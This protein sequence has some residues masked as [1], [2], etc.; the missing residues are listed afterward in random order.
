[1]P[2]PTISTAGRGE[3]SGLGTLKKLRRNDE[4]RLQAS[5]ASYLGYAAR[6]DILWFAVPNGEKRSKATAG[7]LKAQGVRAGVADLVFV[8][9]DGTAAFLELKVNGNRQSPA[10]VEFQASC[11]RMQ[12]PYAVATSFDQAVAILE[13]WGVVR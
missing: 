7:R 8:L 4:E 11:E 3:L 12:V 1:M 9:R 6:K 13:G 10:Q 2:T 5:L